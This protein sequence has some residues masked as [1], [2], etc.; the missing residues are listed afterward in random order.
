MARVLY[1]LG[2]GCARHRRVVLVAWGAIAI[3]ISL[4]ANSVGRETSNNL[5]LPGTNSTAATDLLDAKLPKQA[6]GTNPVVLEARQGDELTSSSNR[7]A[8]DD[9]VKSLERNRYVRSATSPLSS[10][11]KDA[12]SKDKRIGYISVLLTIGPD[13]IDVD[14]A[15]EIIDAADPAS[16]AGLTVAV[17]G[18]LGEEVSKPDTRTSEVVGIVAAI[19]AV[20]TGLSL[21]GLLG[22]VMNVPDVAPTLGIMIGL[23]VGIDYSLFIVTRHRGFMAAGQSVEEAA[24]SAIATSGSAVLFAGS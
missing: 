16:K 19:V 1:R 13:D 3:A 7:K 10:A 20:I 2:A 12:L 24:G 14:Q 17:G 18:Y 8:V 5:S 21:I 22:H 9:T 11:G 4:V 15:N 23:G 6:N